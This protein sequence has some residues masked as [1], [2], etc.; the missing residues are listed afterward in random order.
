MLLQPGVLEHEHIH[1]SEV[2]LVVAELLQMGAR[3]TRVV[4]ES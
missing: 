4:I 2:L 1:V 3:Q